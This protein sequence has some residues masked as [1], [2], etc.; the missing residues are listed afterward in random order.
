ML[1]DLISPYLLRRLKKDVQH[2]LPKKREQV[3]FCRLTDI[4]VHAYHEFLRGNEVKK[5]VQG[6]GLLFRAVTILRQLCNHPDL[7]LHGSEDEVC[8]FFYFFIIHF[9]RQA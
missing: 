1:R 5:C 9:F 4:Q 6:R 7:L 3:L 2:Q 8:K